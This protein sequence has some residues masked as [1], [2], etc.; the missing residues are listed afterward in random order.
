MAQEDESVPN[1]NDNIKSGNQEDAIDWLSLSLVLVQNL[2]LLVLLPMVVGL[3]T[4]AW[5]YTFKP[6]YKATTRFLPPQQQ[7]SAAAAM[8]QSLGNLG[9]LAGAAAGIKNPADQYVAFLKSQRVQYD[10]IDRF[11]LM[12]EFG[13]DDKERS[14]DLLSSVATVTNGLDGLISVT[15]VL[16]DPKKAAD[17][18]NGHVDSLRRLMAGM[19]LTEAQQRR[20]FFE[21]KLDAARTNLLKSEMALRHSGVEAGSLK[22]NPGS[23]IESIGRLRALVTAQEIKIDAMGTYLTEQSPELRAA[24][25]EL[26]ALRRQLVDQGRPGD[27]ADGQAGEYLSKYRIFKYN[28]TLFEILSKQYAAARVDESRDGSVIQVLD[29]AVP[30]RRPVSAHRIQ[31][32]LVAVF[33]SMAI[34][35]AWILIRHALNQVGRTSEGELTVQEIKAK[36]RHAI[37]RS[38]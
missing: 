5:T 14:R 2:R 37:G 12:A 35:I 34:L 16:E 26:Q 27:V 4:L 33:F 18:A 1:V 17:L 20:E 24:K 23:A 11:K 10:L 6:G 9:G 22:M 31:F 32:T 28:E 21:K 8:L 7:Q 38:A 29:T 3:L 30:P 25:A 36:L 19:A 15:V 13:T